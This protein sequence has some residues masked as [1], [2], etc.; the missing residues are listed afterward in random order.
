MEP[1]F[2]IGQRVKIQHKNDKPIFGIIMQILKSD[3]VSYGISCEGYGPGIY[4][5]NEKVVFAPGE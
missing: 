1:K 4:M 5:F 2:R 3:T